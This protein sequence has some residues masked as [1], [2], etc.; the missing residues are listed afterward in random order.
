MQG[1][2]SSLSGSKRRTVAAAERQ[3][4]VDL[5]RQMHLRLDPSKSVTQ[6][7]LA[8]GASDTDAEA[9]SAQAQKLADEEIAA[10]VHLPPSATL[11]F[12]Y[13]FLLGVTPR[14]STARIRRAYRRKAIEVHPDTHAQ[15]FTTGQWNQLMSILTDAHHVLGDPLTRRAY[16]IFWRR[17]SR[18]G[19]DGYRRGGERRGDWELRCR[20]SIA[21]M[22]E[23]EEA[24]VPLIETL[25]LASPGTPARAEVISALRQAADSYEGALI[26]IR[27]QS[28]S[29]PEDL[30]GFAHRVRI[31]MQRK[32]GLV[33]AVRELV[34]AAGAASIVAD[35]VEV[36]A[37]ARAALDVLVDIRVAEDDFDLAEAR[38]YL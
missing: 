11:E 24:M 4:L 12:N 2:F 34:R 6:A 27:T 7:L 15:D 25:P 19:A 36:T 32:E 14:A 16:D 22:G 20:W 28:M 31:Q 23:R 26:E 9:I 3:R 1:I 8:A 17:R 13:Y 30:A 10:T 33:Q 29:L 18:E 38:A 5:A 37:H 21:E 35:N